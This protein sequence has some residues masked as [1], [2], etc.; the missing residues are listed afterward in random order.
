MVQL[1]ALIRLSRPVPQV[2]AE[3]VTVTVMVPLS[4]PPL[5]PLLLLPLPPFPEP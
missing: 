2:G 4:P 1:R 5:L 3:A